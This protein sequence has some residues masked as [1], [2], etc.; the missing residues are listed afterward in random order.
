MH[1]ATVERVQLAEVRIETIAGL[2]EADSD[3]PI[4]PSR[5]E[6]LA[7]IEATS[8]QAVEA[9]RVAVER[10]RGRQRE[11][12]EAAGATGRELGLAQDRHSSVSDRLTAAKDRLAAVAIE[13]AELA[14]R[15]ES[16]AEAL[17]READASE[18]AALAAPRP[19]LDGDLAEVLAT[20]EAELR[21]MG[22]IN[23]LAA[24]EYAEIRDRHAFLAAQLDDLERSRNELRGV[25]DALDQEIQHRFLSAYEEIA[26]AYEEHFS[27]LF[28]GG[29]GRL[30]LTEPDQPLISGVD[31]Q[32]QPLGKKVSKMTLLSGGERSL[33]A[34]AFLFAVFKARPSPFYVLDE[35]EAALDDANLHRFLR[36][37]EA[38]RHDAQLMIVT[39]QQQTMESADVLYG[40][41]MEP[42]GSSKVVAK[43]LHEVRVE[44]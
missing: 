20:K 21:R 8:R 41:T 15:R 5:L 10:L 36:L 16:I 19:D 29:R 13:A 25:I 43:A 18:E 22:P 32:A 34:I 6:R 27:V 3:Q 17:R 23:P 2:V 28:P 7:L 31:I 44:A 33:A 37:M 11:L 39:H 1:R 12:R 9:C 30:R 35:V 26:S 24:A 14:V 42:G 38:F 40:V 4:D